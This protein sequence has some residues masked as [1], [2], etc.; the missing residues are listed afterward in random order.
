MNVLILEDKRNN[1]EALPEIVSSC[2]GVKYVCAYDKCEDALESAM[3][4]HID[5]FLLDIILEQGNV[6]DNSG[7][8]F[9][10]NIRRYDEYKLTPI[11][12]IT[13]LM[14]LM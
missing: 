3:N 7:I 14:G 13:M 1:R 10:R 12:F 5:L 11:I 2:M 9:T 8:L 6:N 4:K